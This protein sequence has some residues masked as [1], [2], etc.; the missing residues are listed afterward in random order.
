MSR[1]RENLK[2][3]SVGPAGRKQISGTGLP[4]EQQYFAIRAVR[5]HLNRQF[6]PQQHGHRYFGNEEVRGI[7]PSGLE[8]LTGVRE[9]AGIEALIAQNQVEAMRTSSSTTEMRSCLPGKVM[10]LGPVIGHSL[11]AD[12]YPIRLTVGYRFQL[13]AQ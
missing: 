10:I 7:I 11:R 6:N 3:V 13:S 5:L 4:G 12:F 1:L 2:I 8:S 9:K